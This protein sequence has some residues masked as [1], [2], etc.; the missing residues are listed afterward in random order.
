MKIY[1]NKFITDKIVQYED[2]DGNRVLIKSDTN[3][4]SFTVKCRPK[5]SRLTV[6][7]I[8][9]KYPYENDG[10]NFDASSNVLTKQETQELFDSLIPFFRETIEII[11]RWFKIQKLLYAY[12]GDTSKF[13]RLITNR[14]KEVNKDKSITSSDVENALLGSLIDEMKNYEELTEFVQLCYLPVTNVKE[15]K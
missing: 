12:Y 3:G 9:F 10:V 8:E 7:P 4:S 11:V 1:K 2:S 15:R 6:S 5:D 13:S 14:V